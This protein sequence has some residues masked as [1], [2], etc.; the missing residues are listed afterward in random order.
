MDSYIPFETALIFLVMAYRVSVTVL[1]V[2]AD[3][4]DRS[5][6]IYP[7]RRI[8]KA[9]YSSNDFVRTLPQHN[10]LSIVLKA[11]SAER[12]KNHDIYSTNPD[13]T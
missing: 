12:G 3:K 13:S 10:K 4:C 5:D 1:L 6:R 11:I 9:Q 2:V 8:T 7:R